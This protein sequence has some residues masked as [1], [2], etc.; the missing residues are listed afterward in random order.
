MQP[1]VGLQW[2]ASGVDHAQPG[3]GTGTIAPVWHSEPEQEGTNSFQLQDYGQGK[4]FAIT[5]C[6]HGAE[7]ETVCCC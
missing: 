7:S 4:V 3:C 1:A 5:E 2:S 6:L